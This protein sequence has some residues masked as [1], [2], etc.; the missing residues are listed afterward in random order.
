MDKWRR[1]GWEREL[2]QAA[3]PQRGKISAVVCYMM[4]KSSTKIE[5]FSPWQL[6]GDD[7]VVEDRGTVACRISESP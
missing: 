5:Q 4:M 6:C 1:E 3:L 2:R 7:I